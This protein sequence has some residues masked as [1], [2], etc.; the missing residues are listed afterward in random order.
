[1]STLPTP[2]ALRVVV[3]GS[4]ARLGAEGTSLVIVVL[5]L[6]RTGS[7]VT[8]G[9][10]LACSTLP[11][12]VT[13]PLAGTVLDSTRRPG[14]V[15]GTALA[16]TALAIVGLAAD[17]A[18]GAGSIA[19][20]LVLS[21]SEPY[22]TGGLKRG[23]RAPGPR[24]ARGGEG[25]L[26][27]RRWPTTWPASA[28]RPRHGGHGMGRGDDGDGLLA[29]GVALALPAMAAPWEALRPDRASAAPSG[30]R[31]A[32]P[33]G[34]PAGAAG[35]HGD[36]VLRVLGVGG[37]SIAA[38]AAACATGRDGTDVGQLITAIALGASAGSIWWTRLR[39]S[40]SPA[41]TVILATAATGVVVVTMGLVPWPLALAGA[42]V[43]G[44][45][46][47]PTL[48]GTYAARHADSPLAVRSSVFTVGA[49]LK[50]AASSV[51]AVVAG[52]TLATATTGRGM[53]VVGALHLVAA[54]LGWWALGAGRT[55]PLAVGV[56]AP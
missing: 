43:I 50:L 56:E 32:G 25:G 9:V 11:Q 7:V 29:A 3:T 30:R 47:V 54:G 28:C 26:L 46:D 12:L 53:V 48:I 20:A 1:M 23:L 15:L 22:L 14:L 33:D 8:A 39:P 2:V 21:A 19:L 41:R 27:G 44:V 37:L 34:A 16:V 5:S 6:E 18:M 31:S 40:P 49:S 10:L 17:T 42:V 13:G 4:L 36:D 55:M 45:L 24:A 38:V 51:G 52:W 35:R